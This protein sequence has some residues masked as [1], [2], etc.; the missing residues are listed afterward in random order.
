MI[1]RLIKRRL[2]SEKLANV[3]VNSLLEITENSFPEVCAMIKDDNAFITTPELEQTASD[4]FLLIIIVGNL[5]YLDDHFEG[6]CFV[7]S[8]TSF[9]E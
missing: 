6:H 5:C 3:F 7:R 9:S 8:K 2:D 1:G 4:N